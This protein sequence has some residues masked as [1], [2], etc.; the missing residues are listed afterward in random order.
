MIMKSDAEN[1]ISKAHRK[2]PRHLFKECLGVWRERVNSFGHHCL[3]KDDHT[4]WNPT[5]LVGFFKNL[6][7]ENKPKF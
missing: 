4:V 7:L 1:A 2:T 6:D 3:N 5:A